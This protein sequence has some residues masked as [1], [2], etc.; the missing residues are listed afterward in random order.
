VLT[1]RP[2]EPLTLGDTTFRFMTAAADEALATARSLAGDADVRIGGGPT[3]AR[4]FL[5]ARLVDRIHTVAVPVVLG[6]GTSLWE[7]L[8]GLERSYDI[9]AASTPSGATHVIWTRRTSEE[10]QRP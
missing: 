6:R 7:G 3:T 10:R 4:Q 2:R 5:G 9:E 8:E 1:H